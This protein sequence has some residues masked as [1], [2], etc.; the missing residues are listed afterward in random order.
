[1]T[2]ERRITKR[3]TVYTDRFPR[4]PALIFVVRVWRMPDHSLGAEI[5]V[6]KSKVVVIRR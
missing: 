3:V 6:G 1:M 5:R 4:M 2:R